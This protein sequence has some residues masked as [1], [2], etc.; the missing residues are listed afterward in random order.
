MLVSCSMLMSNMS[1]N[2]SF[3]IFWIV[4]WRRPR[5][6]ICSA[7]KC[8]GLHACLSMLQTTVQDSKRKQERLEED[9]MTLRRKTTWQEDEFNR[10][11]TQLEEE[12]SARRRTEKHLK[13]MMV[14]L[15]KQLHIR[16]EFL[17]VQYVCMCVYMYCNQPYPNG[18]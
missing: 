3:N 16:S 7:S 17:C 10:V 18:R 4:N 6:A 15:K 2:A 5:H 9:N 8:G 12:S 13:T 1:W 11:S 14:Q